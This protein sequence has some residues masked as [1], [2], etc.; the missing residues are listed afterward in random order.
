MRIEYENI[1]CP[2]CEGRGF[3][4]ECADGLTMEA[5]EETQAA[6]HLE[7][8]LERAASETHESEELSDGV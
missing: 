8:E 3:C 1:W 6:Y 2:I 7:S 4:L 5:Y